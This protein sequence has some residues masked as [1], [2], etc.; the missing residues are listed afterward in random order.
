MALAT[1]SQLKTIHVYGA[2]AKLLKRRTFKADVRSPQEA[3]GFLLSNFPEAEA[4]IRPRFFHIRVGQRQVSE[5]DI[6]SPVGSDEEICITPA[7]C[8][9]GGNGLFQ[10]IAGAFLIAVSI[11]VPFTAPL[12]L[13]LG[14]GLTLTG[15]STLL[16]P[17]PADRSESTNPSERDSYNF[18]G[19]QQTSREGVPVPLVYGEIFTGSVTLSVKVDEDEEPPPPVD[20][21][22]CGGDIKIPGLDFGEAEVPTGFYVGG[23]PPAGGENYNVNIWFQPTVIGQSYE[24]YG[25]KTD[26]DRP[27]CGGLF[28]AFYE[29]CSG[30]NLDSWST[31]TIQWDQW[32]A[33][34]IKW[35][36]RWVQVLGNG[37]TGSVL[38]T[39]HCI[40]AGQWKLAFTYDQNGQ[41]Q[42]PVPNEFEM[43]DRDGSRIAARKDGRYYTQT[44][45]VGDSYQRGTNSCDISTSVG[46]PTEPAFKI[47]RIDL[48]D[49]GNGV[50]IR[51]LWTSSSYI[52][53]DPG[54]LGP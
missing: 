38:N 30:C 15:V 43:E 41:L 19:L 27:G 42:L 31:T 3:I 23:S 13:P 29:C 20:Q 28:S 6:D 16:T 21:R 40:D 44:L 49:P 2:L 17:T 50:S 39:E 53:N 52:E 34:N 11:F 24:T 18:N 33:K 5:K 46:C 45:R 8:G 48:A 51:N 37:S 32:Y 25:F 54:P 22:G 7:I 47:V 9:A 36:V 14:L 4:Y 10:I 35:P 26:S 1:N 12:L